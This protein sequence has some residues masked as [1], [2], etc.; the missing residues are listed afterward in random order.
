MWAFLSGLLLLAG[1][2]FSATRYTLKLA[3]EAEAGGGGER[4]KIRIVRTR[5]HQESSDAAADRTRRSRLLARPLVLRPLSFGRWI[6]GGFGTF[7][8]VIQ[9]FVGIAL[10]AVACPVPLAFRAQAHA[11]EPA[12]QARPHLPAY[13]SRSGRSLRYSRLG[14]VAYVAAGQFAIHLVDSRILN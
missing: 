4:C 2:H 12:Q 6:S 9:I 8:G 10:V 7:L 5:R 1:A 14:V 11:L 13:R 3:R